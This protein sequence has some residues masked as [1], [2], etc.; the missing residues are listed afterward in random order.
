MILMILGVSFA[1]LGIMQAMIANERH[2]NPAFQTTPSASRG[3]WILR[4]S[5]LGPILLVVIV[6]TRL[7]PDRLNLTALVELAL[8][9]IGTG[10]YLTWGWPALMRKLGVFRPA[11]ARLQDIVARLAAESGIAV[12]GAEQVALPMANA[13]ALPLDGKLGM[14]DAA[15][16]AL[17]DD[18]VRV[19]CAH[20]LAHLAEPRRFLVVRV[21]RGFILGLFL[22]ILTVAGRPVTGSYGL[23]GTLA[24]IAGAFLVLF[25]S[26]ILL[27]R[28]N[29]KMEHRADAQAV[30]WEPSAGLYAR[31]LEKLYEA[32]LM[33][34]VL[35]SKRMTHPDLYD[36]M[37]Q[38]GAT[39]DYPRPAPPPRWPGLLGLAALLIAA[40]LGVIAYRF[41]TADLPHTLL[42]PTEAAYWRIGAGR[43]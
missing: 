13:F 41:V 21:L 7:V 37:V 40:A 19:I 28:F 24:G 2:V 8:L 36:R 11:S 39:P 38:S 23:M 5:I 3:A 31:A 14:T 17:D 4:L 33:P 18:E 43:P 6:A 29:R 25:V 22:A 10:M 32:N 30:G 34:A 12:R 20:E 35:R 15:L 1:L 27:N 16:S 42:G 9:V 26:S